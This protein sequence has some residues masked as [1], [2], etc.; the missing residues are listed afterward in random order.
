MLVCKYAPEENNILESVVL[1][2]ALKESTQPNN[3]ISS[4]MRIDSILFT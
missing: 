2:A 3:F 4:Y 1:Y